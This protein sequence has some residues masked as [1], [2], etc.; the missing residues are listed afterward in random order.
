MAKRR[1]NANDENVQRDLAELPGVLDRIDS[2]IADGVI[3]GE[4]PNAADYQIAPSVRQLLTMEDLRP[5]VESRPAG[6]LALRLIPDFPGQLPPVFPADWLAS[7]R[8]EA[9]AA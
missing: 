9:P 5:A 3:G 4:A 2:L 8:A 7:L 1:N 6:Q